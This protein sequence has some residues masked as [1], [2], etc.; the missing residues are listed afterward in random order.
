MASA[1]YQEAVAW[2]ADGGAL[3]MAPVAVSASL[4]AAGLARSWG[5]SLDDVPDIA[6]YLCAGFLRLVGDANVEGFEE[7]R[8]EVRSVRP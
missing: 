8:T 7:W 6:A 1:V 2:K 3:N 5:L 4:A